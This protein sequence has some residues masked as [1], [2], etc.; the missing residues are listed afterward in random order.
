MH[1]IHHARVAEDHKDFYVI[2]LENPEKA[3]CVV[4]VRVAGGRGVAG[5]RD[6]H[7]SSGAAR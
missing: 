1:R 6:R 5:A 4:P 2:S 7:G 3:V